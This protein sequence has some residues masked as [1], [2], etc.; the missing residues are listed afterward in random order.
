MAWNAGVLPD[1]LVQHTKTGKNK[2]TKWAKINPMT[3]NI[4][5]GNTYNLQ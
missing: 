4:Q 3:I 1:F 5:N 2:Y